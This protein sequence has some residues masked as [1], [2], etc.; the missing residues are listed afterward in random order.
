MNWYIVIALTIIA[1]IA[2]YLA[3]KTFN[4]EDDN[5]KKD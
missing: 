3:K 4:K 1:W 2:L 5:G